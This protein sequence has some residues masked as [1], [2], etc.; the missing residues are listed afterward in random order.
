MF[1][2]P[3]RFVNVVRSIDDGMMATVLFQ[4]EET[5]AIGVGVG[6]K[7]SCAMA[8]VLFKINLTTAI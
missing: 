1:G 7:Q 4:G 8:H 6:V 5:D 2:C 3:T